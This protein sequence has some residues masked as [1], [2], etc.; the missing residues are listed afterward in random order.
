MMTEPVPT[1]IWAVP[2]SRS[3]ALTKSLS[4]IQNSKIFHELYTN[5]FYFGPDN[6]VGPAPPKLSTEATSEVDRKIVDGGCVFP[7]SVTSYDWVKNTLARDYPGKVVIS[8]EMPFCL[9]YKYDSLPKGY[10]HVFLIRHPRDVFLSWKRVDYEISQAQSNQAPVPF[11]D[12]QLDNAET[13]SYTTVFKQS[14]ELYQYLKE[15]HLDENPAIIDGDD[16]MN[17]PAGM[18]EALCIKL[19]LPYSDH[20]LTWDKGISDTWTISDKFK[21]LIENIPA[22]ESFRDSTGFKRRSPGKG[23]SSGDAEITADM[24]RCI[25]PNMPFYLKMYEQRLKVEHA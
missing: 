17:D 12:Y 21:P 16:L 14:Y 4:G 24:Q 2:R 9:D 19:G 25:D 3:N 23:A 13:I 18:L 1:I 22:F 15:N 7:S 8:K 5:A 20:L 11:K 10:R 6:R